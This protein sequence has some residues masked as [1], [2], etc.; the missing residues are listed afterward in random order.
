MQPAYLP[1]P[2]YF[3]RMAQCEVLI[4]WDHVAFSDKHRDNFVNRNRIRDGASWRWLTIPVH[5]PFGTRICDVRTADDQ[6]AA[7]HA[8]AIRAAYPE[9]DWSWLRL[10]PV[11]GLVDACLATVASCCGRLGM[12][13]PRIVRGSRLALPAGKTEALLAACRIVGATAYLSGPQGRAYLDLPAW[14]AAG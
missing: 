10:E 12:A 9:S 5:A 11:S 3:D 14:D 7:R 13:D 8:R 1:W 4:L 6:W 2:G